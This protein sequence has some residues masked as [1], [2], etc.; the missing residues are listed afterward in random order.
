MGYIHLEVGNASDYD[1][2]VGSGPKEAR[3][4]MDRL[5]SPLVDNSYHAPMIGLSGIIP[6]G[7][8]ASFIFEGMA[9]IR[10][11]HKIAEYSEEVVLHDVRYVSGG[12][13]D[14]FFP[15]YFGLQNTKRKILRFTKAN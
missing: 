4:I 11:H 9:F 7:K 10:G 3:A 2:Y 13:W 6:V 12:Q 15:I 14:G 8:K 5:V 1:R